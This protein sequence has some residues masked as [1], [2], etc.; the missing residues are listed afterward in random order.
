MIQLSVQIGKDSFCCSLSVPGIVLL[1]NAQINNFNARKRG[2]SSMECN[3]ASSAIS[4]LPTRF[5]VSFRPAL[6]FR[7]VMMKGKKKFTFQS[8]PLHPNDEVNT[9]LVVYTFMCI[10]QIKWIMKLRQYNWSG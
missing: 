7:G 8:L 2:F 9:C 3:R 10:K 5:R 4:G 1:R 6:E